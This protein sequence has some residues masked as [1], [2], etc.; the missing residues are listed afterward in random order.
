MHIAGESL[1]LRTFSGD[2]AIVSFA[3]IAKRQASF[4]SGFIAIASMEETDI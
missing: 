4:A 1:M 2:P 3:N